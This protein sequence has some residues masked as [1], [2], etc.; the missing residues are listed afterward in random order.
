MRKFLT[1]ALSALLF[2]VANLSAQYYDW[3]QDPASVRW[4][5]IKTPD[6]KYIFPDTYRN[7][8][9][10]IMHLMDTIRPWI[11]YGYTHGPM[12][13]MPL[14]IHTQNFNS[15]GI[16]MLAPKRI[17][18]IVTP[19]SDHFAFPAL[20]Q[21]SIHEYRHA[22]QYNNLNRG[23]VRALNYVLG[24]QGALIGMAFMPVWAM[25]GDAVMAE[26]QAATCGR[27]TQPSFSIEYR[28]MALEG[29]NTYPIDKYF[30]GSYKDYM[31]DHYRLG[32]QIM[33]WADTRYGENILNK[34]SRYAARNPYFF[35]PF[36]IAL[37]KYYGTSEG[38]LFRDSFGDL[39]DYWRSLPVDDNTAS[40]VPTPWSSY[41]TYTAPRALSTTEAVVLKS[42]LDRT[43]RLVKVDTGTGAETVLC[44]TGIVN[45][46][47]SV[48]R[49]RIYWTEYRQST[50]WEQRVSSQLCWYDLQSGRKGVDP[51]MRNVMFPVAVPDGSLAAV[52]YN[53][54]GTYTIVHGANRW[55]LPQ[56]VTVHGLA[57]EP[58]TARLYF[59]GLG[60][61]GMW[62]GSVADGRGE[63]AE[64]T[65]PAYV[66]LA[67]LSAGDG[68]LYFKSIASGKDE[69]H[70]YDLA[71]GKQFRITTSRYGS[72]DPSPMGAGAVMTT[73]TPK[74]YLLSHQKIEK[75]AL[76]EVPYTEAPHNAV[77]PPRRRW[78]I[79]N[80]DRVTVSDTTRRE[81]KKYRKG[82]NL[83]Y[84]HS[85]APV[86]F[87]PDRIMS[88]ARFD[89]NAGVTFMSQN[90]LNS[91]Y[92]EV[93]YGWTGSHSL[94]HGKF[95]YYGWAPKIELDAL[96]SNRDQ[97]IAGRA[98]ND[99]M[100]KKVADYWE[101]TARAYLPITL[102]SGAS[103]RT[104]TPSVEYQYNNTKLYYPESFDF[105][106]GL[107]KLIFGLQYV[108]SRR[109]SHRDFLPRFGYAVRANFTMNPTNDDFGKL[110][111][112]YG[113]VY[114][115]G[116]GRHHSLMLRGAV[117][118]Q[119][120]GR[121]IYRQKEV[122]PRGAD[123]DRVMPQRYG[124]LS[125][126]YQFPLWYP[127]GGINSILYFRRVRLNLFGDG[128]RYKDFGT[129]SSAP[130]WNTVW[131][132]GADLILDMVPLRL[133]S[134]TTMTVTLSIR[135]PS[136][137]NGVV[138][139]FNIS[140]PL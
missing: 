137:R 56:T 100:P 140:L 2:S 89:I 23:V 18:L 71:S 123:F 110:W 51:D 53:I 101:F 35:F 81:V 133:P 90:N 99:P 6:I 50:F 112:L 38:R 95:N 40:I 58:T 14:I 42:D 10:R 102:S 43:S 138:G 26:T 93:G 106:V 66:T 96:W 37:K 116:I 63:F 24:Q 33:S 121:Y 45:S 92:T 136:D 135:K 132:Y 52:E 72:F 119:K 108:E 11:G 12:T 19:E 67:D 64:V 1:L 122:F 105:R 113:R 5:T 114:L 31:P 125:A 8:A 94:V 22:V 76:V 126:D 104:L 83:F 97:T 84:F 3:G 124:A 131:S 60:N 107:N 120:A 59:I 74:G 36:S 82:A 29:D 85:W 61:D 49:D 111:S 80:M 128:A 70:M 65:R 34:T 118:E 130:R 4:R 88:E 91:A 30:C 20:K 48:G 15:N 46:P 68:A 39:Y 44:Y 25:E 129:T 21:L 47:L 62:I 98:D 32:Y 134:N 41:T 55:P 54:D 9:V 17:E 73:Y 115:P 86:Y 139:G 78:D 117:Q 16:V 77:N 27:G 127:D 103:F 13:R 109:M 79:P 57:W 87:E 75:S 28:A 69:A 7:N